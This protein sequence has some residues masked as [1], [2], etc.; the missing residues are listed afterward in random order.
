MKFKNISTFHF[1]LS[2]RKGI[3]ALPTILIMGSIIVEITIAATVSA[4]L[5]VNTEAG[6]R[7][8]EAALLAAKSGANDALL[9]ITRDRTFSSSLY[10]LPVG[11]GVQ[12]D[13]IVAAEGFNKKK[14]TATGSLRNWKRKIEAV[15]SLDDQTGLIRLESMDEVPL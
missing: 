1:P 8:S 5:V 2:T 10:Q 13:V 12:A 3:A 6:A 4:F 9:R 15:V 11:V 14:V 7:F